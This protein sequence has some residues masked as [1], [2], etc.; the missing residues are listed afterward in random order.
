MK[1][2]T[3][4]YSINRKSKYDTRLTIGMEVLIPKGEKIDTSATVQLNPIGY[5]IG[6]VPDAAFAMLYLSAIVYAIDRSV[7]R[8]RFSVDGWSREFDVEISI[9]CVNLFKQIESKINSMLSYLTGDYWEC[10]FVGD[11]TMNLENGWDGFA[12]WSD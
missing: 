4:T 11:A 3:T 7:S 1:I 6:K 12:H 2:R 5:F 9:P 10:H 8:G